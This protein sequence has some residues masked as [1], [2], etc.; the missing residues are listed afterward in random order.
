VHHTRIPPRPTTGSEG[1][2]KEEMKAGMAALVM[3]LKRLKPRCLVFNGKCIFTSL[4]PR[5]VKLG[6]DWKYGVQTSKMA[7]HIFPLSVTK[8]TK[9]VVVCVCCVC[10]VIFLLSSLH[11]LYARALD[12]QTPSSSPRVASYQFADKLVFF[13]EIKA[14]VDG[15][16]HQD[17]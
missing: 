16:N 1:V 11:S 8:D 2:G 17:Q 6:K 12:T 4:L 15:E 7:G 5:G 13:Q 3:T 9:L 10:D 14:L